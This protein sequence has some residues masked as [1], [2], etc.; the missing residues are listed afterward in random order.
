MNVPQHIA[1]IL[2]GNGTMGKSQGNAEKLRA[3]T[4]Q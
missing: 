4:G 1:I 2:D 3:C